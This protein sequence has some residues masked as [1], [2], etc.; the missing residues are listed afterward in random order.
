MKKRRYILKKYEPPRTPVRVDLTYTSRSLTLA[1]QFT[2]AAITHNNGPAIC[3]PWNTIAFEP[4]RI[5]RMR[6]N[7]G[8]R[9]V[10]VHVTMTSG[11][12]FSARCCLIHVND[13][14]NRGTVALRQV[15]Q[16]GRTPFWM[17]NGYRRGHH[18]TLTPVHQS[19]KRGA[20]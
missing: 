7:S 11:E 1:E 4:R 15:V 13:E 10:I 6:Y 12:Q 14:W 18:V 19:R 9:L 16:R 20:A 5:M 3:R 2:V 17:F 8:N